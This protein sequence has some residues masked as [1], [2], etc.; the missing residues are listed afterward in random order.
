MGTLFLA[1]ITLRSAKV[2]RM[3]IA[4]TIAL[5]LLFIQ[6]AVALPTLC[7]GA[8]TVGDYSYTLINP[9]ATVP[10]QCKDSCAYTRDDQEGSMYCFAVGEEVVQCQ[11]ERAINWCYPRY[12]GC[13]PKENVS[14]WSIGDDPTTITERDSYGLCLDFCRYLCLNSPDGYCD[15]Q[16]WK[17]NSS[18]QLCYTYAGD[19][20]ESVEE[21][22]FW[23][24]GLC[25]ESDTEAKDF[26]SEGDSKPEY[27]KRT[28]GNLRS[29]TTP[30]RDKDNAT[31]GGDII[32]VTVYV[33]KYADGVEAIVGIQV[34]YNGLVA[35]LHG[36][37]NG[38]A[39]E[40][41]ANSKDGIL[42][43]G[44]HGNA[45]SFPGPTSFIYSIAFDKTNERGT[46]VGNLNGG[47]PFEFTYPN[48]KLK[49]I[50]G[51]VTS[52]IPSMLGSVTFWF[53]RI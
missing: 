8:K 27:Y 35:D 39:Y 24:G 49:F 52:E 26:S 51:M 31:A 48:Y 46:A 43:E 45:F 3:K 4:V 1:S 11:G 40:F 53:Y 16:A 36:N 37:N 22:A 5:L 9:D 14:F 10:S 44:V 7:C 18:S 30:F 33:G 12:G 19:C 47:R 29:A 20:Y 13:P 28:A 23:S 41:T 17:W 38:K 34:D 25:L 42:M 50:S 2:L 6:A 15:C 21:N 32:K